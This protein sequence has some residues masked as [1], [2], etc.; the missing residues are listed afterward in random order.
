MNTQDNINL[1]KEYLEVV[2]CTYK[3]LCNI[4]KPVNGRLYHTSDTNEFYFDWANKRQKLSV[5]STGGASNG[6]VLTKTELKNWLKEND[7]ITNLSLADEL[8]KVIGSPIKNIITLKALEDYANKHLL[9]KSELNLLDN[10]LQFAE[11]IKALKSTNTNFYNSLSSV[12]NEVRINGEKMITSEKLNNKL[13]EYV[14]KAFADSVYLSKE[15]ANIYIDDEGFRKRIKDYLKKSDADGSYVKK[16]ELSKYETKNDLIDKLSVFSK[17]IWV[18]EYYMKKKDMKDYE[19]ISSINEKL[20]QY[21]TGT[22]FENKFKNYLTADEISKK[23]LK[24]GEAGEVIT[25]DE[26]N[27]A[28]GVFAKKIWVDE[29]Y[30][31]KKDMKDYETTSSVNEKLNGYATTSSVENKL[32]GYLTKDESNKFVKK[33]EMDNTVTSDE[34]ND[35]LG[36][37]AKKIWVDEYYVK[38]TQLSDYFTKSEINNIF[39]KKSE[40]NKFL[41]K[42]DAE[43]TYAKK[44][45]IPEPID[46]GKFFLKKDAD[47]MAKKIW[48]DEYYLKKSDYEGPKNAVIISTEFSNRTDFN[49]YYTSTPDAKQGFYYLKDDSELWVIINNG[50]TKMNMNLTTGE[51]IIEYKM[52]FGGTAATQW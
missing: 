24:K 9:T 15:D 46:E 2:T 1:K 31:K 23:Y 16:G 21:V 35:I 7:Y 22:S 4:K 11:D 18:D 39:V 48:V 3:E 37:F 49:N 33:E 32:K 13:M 34:L 12:I 14:D 38:K 8:V 52:N 28:L 51:T 20:K 47:T 36:A 25:P 26:L 5:F 29:Y 17:K 19:T 27:N 50:D 43:N 45:D 30:M 44:T 6:N 41:L 10:P 40:T 42:S